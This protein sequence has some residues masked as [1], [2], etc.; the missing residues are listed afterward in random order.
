MS[1]Y[2]LWGIKCFDNFTL[3]NDDCYFAGGFAVVFLA[4]GSNNKKFALKRMYVN[5]DHDLE[6]AKREIKIAVSKT[7]I[8]TP[9][10]YHYTK[11]LNDR[12]KLHL[13]SY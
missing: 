5:N 9:I 3:L 12:P 4:K 1:V 11:I 10:L 8:N 2:V 13:I 7:N 6:I